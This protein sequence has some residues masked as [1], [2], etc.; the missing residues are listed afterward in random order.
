[1]VRSLINKKAISLIEVLVVLLIASTTL[2]GAISLMSRSFIEIRNN[3]LADTA[4][5]ILINSS[6]II[7]S[8]T[9]INIKM[10]SPLGSLSTVA[11]HFNLT[12]EGGV[13]LLKEPSTNPSS[14]QL[15]T[16]P[17]NSLFLYN[18]Q[19]LAGD[20]TNVP[21][22]AQVNR[23]CLII[24]IRELNLDAT[25]KYYDIDTK[26]IFHIDGREI[27]NKFKIYRYEQF[28]FIN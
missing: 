16:C 13:L 23:A 27:T 17:T 6:E 3:E 24:S 18:P 22:I 15:N 1:M 5:G 21:L 11:K 12:R 9:N 10:F 14:S 4:T 26:I 7:K 28:T 20:T 25:R 2:L 8:P 19:T